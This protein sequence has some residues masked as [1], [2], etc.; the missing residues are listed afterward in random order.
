MIIEINIGQF[1][2]KIDFKLFVA[3]RKNSVPTP[4]HKCT[5]MEV[6]EN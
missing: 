1:L 4:K 5:P 3:E 6:G 2:T